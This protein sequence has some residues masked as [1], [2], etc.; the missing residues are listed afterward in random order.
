MYSIPPGRQGR[1][2]GCRYL[3]Y[4]I[5]G[6]S[7]VL[8]QSF[9]LPF[10]FKASKFAIDSAPQIASKL[11]SQSRGFAAV[12]QPLTSHREVI[13]CAEQITEPDPVRLSR[14]ISCPRRKAGLG[15]RIKAIKYH[16]PHSGLSKEN[17]KSDELSEKRPIWPS[18]VRIIN[19]ITRFLSSSVGLCTSSRRGEL[20]QDGTG[21][22]AESPQ[23]LTITPAKSH[24]PLRWCSR[25]NPPPR[26][27]SELHLCLLSS[28]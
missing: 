5:K 18:G 24:N 6:I 9:Y 1:V 7:L 20:Q 2:G 26:A 16:H 15:M 11:L 19:L 17:Q 23:I 28:L 25:R 14:F 8:T 10:R 4:N 22:S 13:Y 3:M 21:A 27:G 12:H